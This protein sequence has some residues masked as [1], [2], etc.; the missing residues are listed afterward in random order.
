MS[1]VFVNPAELPEAIGFSHA[2]VVEAGRIVFLAGQAGHRADGTIPEGLLDQFAQSC[3]NV[4]SAL[5][6][7]GAARTDL[8][9]L[10]I[11]VTDVDVYRSL[12]RELGEAYREVFG[13][14][15]PPMALFGIRELFDPVARVE[16][17]GMAVISVK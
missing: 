17:V 12:R 3:R 11:F 9:N 15:Y 16:L 4:A 13:R 1:H 2:A 7:A 10:H 6:A 5:E 8:V 14:H